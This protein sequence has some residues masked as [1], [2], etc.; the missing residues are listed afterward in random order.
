MTDE[1]DFEALRAKRNTAVQ[2]MI[3][4][5]CDR[6]GW[7]YGEMHSTFNPNS[8]Y[9]ACVERGP[10]EHKFENWRET[11]ND[12]GE[13]CGGETFCSRCGMGAMSHSLR[14]M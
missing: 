3:Q 10:C 7:N 8:C 6:R 9:C 2:K 13:V 12:R 11:H 1:V 14:F 4:E 5:E